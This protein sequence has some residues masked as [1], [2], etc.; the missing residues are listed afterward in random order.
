MAV[1]APRVV[2]VEH[3]FGQT[4]GK[5]GDVQTQKSVLRATLAAFQKIEKPGGI[6]H[7]PHSWNGNPKE[8]EH[9]EAPPI[10]SY[11]V[12]HPWHVRNLLKRKIPDSFLVMG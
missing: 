5:P 8:L 3:P 4:V 9:P 10:A 7:L 2:G 1:S 6:V 12:R 11:L